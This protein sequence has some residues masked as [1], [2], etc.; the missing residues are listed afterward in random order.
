MNLHMCWLLAF[1][2][3]VIGGLRTMTAARRCWAAK[4][5]LAQS[6]NSPLALNRVPWCRPCLYPGLLSVN[7]SSTNFLDPNRTRLLGLVGRSV[8]GGCLARLSLLPGRIDRTRHRSWCGR[9]I[10][11]AF[12]GYE[13]RKRLVRALKVPDFRHRSL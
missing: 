1:L 11:G 3:G 6:S 5:A 10:A 7:W 12:G 13:V 2:I 9:A 8:L 4:P